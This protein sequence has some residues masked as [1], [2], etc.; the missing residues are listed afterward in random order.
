MEDDVIIKRGYKCKKVFCSI[1][2]K[3][4]IKQIGEIN[5]KTREQ[6]PFV[7]KSCTLT[8]RNK[9]NAKTNCTICGVLLTTE[10]EVRYGKNKLV[11]RYV[12][13]CRTCYKKQAK[14]NYWEAK[15]KVINHYGGKC[16]CCGESIPEFLTVD[17]INNDGKKHREES[18]YSVGNN[19][20]KTL[21]RKNFDVGYELQL[22]CWNCNE[23]KNYYGECPHSKNNYKQETC[24]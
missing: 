6:I 3:V 1:C 14:D 17:H 21:L 22:L 4:I 9:R 19:F 24:D 5:R 12:A 18:P 13:K 2:G 16:A 11:K 23:A 10:N 7:C 8:E 15:L 20:Y